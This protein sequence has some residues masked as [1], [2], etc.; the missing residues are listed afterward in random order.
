VK[1]PQ[2]GK[3]MN[4]NKA[5]P[6]FLS[7]LGFAAAFAALFSFTPFD[8]YA[9]RPPKGQ[10]VSS[11]CPYCEKTFPCSGGAVEAHV[12][13]QHL[14]GDPR[15]G[16]RR[17][18]SSRSS[19]SSY[20]N[21]SQV[22]G[23]T[24][25]FMGALNGIM[26]SAG[27]GSSYQRPVS[28]D[29]IQYHASI[30][31]RSNPEYSKAY[32]LWLEKQ[33]KP[34]FKSSHYIQLLKMAE[35]SKKILEEGGLGNISEFDSKARELAQTPSKWEEA[36]HLLDIAGADAGKEW[37][38]V[39]DK[40]EADIRPE[41]GWSADCAAVDFSG[42]KNF[43]VMK[44]GIPSIEPFYDA[45]PDFNVPEVPD[46]VET[47]LG[48]WK[49]DHPIQSA[50]RSFDCKTCAKVAATAIILTPG[51]KTGWHLACR[52]VPPFGSGRDVRVLGR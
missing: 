40:F 24:Q 48:K 34:E 22:L 16:G 15:C 12:C 20:G 46:I 19:S 26:S 37:G 5:M 35:A 36:L 49:K 44:D 38:G 47:E 30:A 50:L 29:E 1:D 4:K 8:L 2:R 9:L 43:P 31:E 23:M 10:C 11:I 52:P 18:S 7:A 21:A 25:S 42:D 14:R 51:A 27:S 32:D 41:A 33:T 3:F 6:V 39:I 28:I 45:P 17:K 13:S